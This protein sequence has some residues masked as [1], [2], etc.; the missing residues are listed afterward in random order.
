VS[1][2]LPVWQ[3]WMTRWSAPSEL[4]AEPP[5]EAIRAWGRLGYPRRALRLHEAATAIARRHG[6]RV[7]ADYD[8]LLAL[9]G[10]GRYTAAA[11]ACF[12]YGR[13]HAVVDTNVRRVHARAV[14]GTA[15]AGPALTAA[16]L[17]LA[18]ALLPEEP[19]RAVRWSVGVME[20]GALVCTART[21]RCSE[22]PLASLCR[23]RLA[24]APPDAG[25]PRRGQLWAGTDRQVRGR[26]MAALRAA[27][28]ALDRSALIAAVPD[29]SLRDPAQ[30]DRCLAGLITDGLVE[31]LD[32][33]RFALPS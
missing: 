5:G 14:G 23:W 8:V 17:H 6:G 25:P 24:G 19:T 1:R 10:I 11:V 28:D 29:P 21:P 2:V 31:P 26:L 18:E 33:D 20:L 30:R 12:A 13:R 9:P 4:A 32:G 7:P 22:C 16:E 15:Q 27:S 3:E